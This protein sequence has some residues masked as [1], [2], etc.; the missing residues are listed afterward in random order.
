MKR[1]F[2]AML[3]L[4]CATEPKE[5]YGCLDNQAC[6]YN[7]L[8]TIDSDSCI[9]EIDCNGMCGGEAIYDECGICEG[10]G[11]DYDND[12]VCDNI[13]DCIGELD[14]CGECNGNNQS[15]DDCGICYG[16]GSSCLFSFGSFST[17]DILS[18]NIENFPK[19]GN[20]TINLLSNI[21]QGLNVDIIALQEIEGLA[22][23]NDLIESLECEIIQNG[24]YGDCSKS[25]GW[26]NTINGCVE[27][28][29]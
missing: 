17:L 29:G 22:S 13:D 28:F 27:I 19:N 21:I 3:L 25:L 14:E 10:N 18:W 20:I 15:K 23:F 12:G 6:N 1:Q 7:S 24:I 4:G 26:G 2:L 8:A 9:Y 11:I 5:I 16:D